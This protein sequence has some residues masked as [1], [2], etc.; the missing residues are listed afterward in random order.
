MK[1]RGVTRTEVLVLLTTAALGFGFAGPLSNNVR[2]QARDAKCQRNLGLIGQL[3]ASVA[4]ADRWSVLHGQSS[5]GE[6][7]WRGLGAWDWGGLDGACGEVRTGWPSYPEVALAGSTRP[8]TRAAYGDAILVNPTAS[9]FACPA[10]TGAVSDVFYVPV[11]SDPAPCTQEEADAIVRRSMAEAKGTSYQGDFIW[12]SA[13]SDSSAGA[14][15]GSFMRPSELFV[16]PAETLLFYEARFAQAFMCS[17]ESVS[18]WGSGKPSSIASWHESSGA[19]NILNADGHVQSVV[20]NVSGSLLDPLSLPSDLVIRFRGA[21]WRYDAYPEARILE[22]GPGI[23]MPGNPD[24]NGFRQF[25]VE[26]RARFSTPAQ[27][28]H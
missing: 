11:Y 23:P 22:R 25:G 19:Q 17:E 26:T 5:S 2:D 28:D 7:A 15:E 9:L 18:I 12:Y 16:N 1:Q 3:A 20:I 10:D 6:L 14:R 13:S 24:A 4:A 21:G 27:A 8:F